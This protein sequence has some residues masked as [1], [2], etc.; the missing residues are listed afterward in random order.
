MLD[1]DTVFF[2]VLKV[3]LPYFWH[4]YSKGSIHK[5]FV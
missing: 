1:E 3:Y 2:L 4:P 5:T